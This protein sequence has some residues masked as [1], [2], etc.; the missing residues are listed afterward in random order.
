M[1]DI[2][3]VRGYDHCATTSMRI[4]HVATDRHETHGLKNEPSGCHSL[5][6]RSRPQMNELHGHIFVIEVMGRIQC[7][8]EE[9]SVPV[10]EDAR[11]SQPSRTLTSFSTSIRNGYGL[12]WNDRCHS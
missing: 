8:C 4:P 5:E 3:I 10:I 11:S 2:R 12:S 1:R 6:A 7:H 9:R